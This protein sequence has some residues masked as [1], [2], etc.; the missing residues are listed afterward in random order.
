MEHT[1]PW[2]SPSPELPHDRRAHSALD[3]AETHPTR[4][5]VPSD[6]P[7]QRP[8]DSIPQGTDAT[9]RT[10]LRLTLSSLTPNRAST[11]S[12]MKSISMRTERASNSTTRTPGE[13]RTTITKFDQ[14]RSQEDHRVPRETLPLH[15]PGTPP[16][17]SKIDPPPPHATTLGKFRHVTKHTN[18]LGEK[19]SNPIRIRDASEP[20]SPPRQPSVHY[21]ESDARHGGVARH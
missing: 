11:H 20:S 15:E 3:S 7:H 5:T 2:Q 21:D 9:H 14:Q 18:P 6:H 4:Q 17:R 1:H 19:N 16:Q 12:T 10:T 13:L 8:E